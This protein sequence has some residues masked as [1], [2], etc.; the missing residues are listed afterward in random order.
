M[1]TESESTWPT[2][3]HK[4]AE[5]T[6]RDA[7]RTDDPVRLH[8]AAAMLDAI[9]YGIE[10]AETQP[11]TEKDIATAFAQRRGLYLDE[12]DGRFSL[13]DISAREEIVG[14]DASLADVLAYLDLDDASSAD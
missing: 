9:A 3:I 7:L 12:E 4:A 1:T 8:R 10:D 13:I 2:T 14:P 6:A 11:P 5:A